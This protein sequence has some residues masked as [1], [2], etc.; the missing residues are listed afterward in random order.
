MKMA[1]VSDKHVHCAMLGDG[2]VGKTCLTLSYIE[3]CFTESYTATV[4]D[5]YPVPLEVGGQDFVI[6]LFDTA[7]QN[8]FE[9]LRAYTYKE[10]EVLVLCFSVIDR[11][12]FSSVC[13]SWVPE[14]K[15]HT[16]RRR[17]VILVGTQIDMRRGEEQEVSTEEGEAMAR[18]IGA[19][20]YIE[21]SAKRKD[22]LKEVFEH[23]VFSALK[24]RKKKVNI[25]ERFFSR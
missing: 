13:N 3:K 7:G 11:D 20:C 9:D 17:P 14:I 4:F 23:V 25:I 16:K 21:C 6:S 8:D 1:C 15:R 22:G 5:N 10:S 24:F 18:A 19:D 12:S 2:M